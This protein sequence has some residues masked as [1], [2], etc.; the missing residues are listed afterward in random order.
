MLL[1]STQFPHTPSLSFQKHPPFLPPPSFHKKG[2]SPYQVPGILPGS[3]GP[4]D[5]VPFHMRL[6][7]TSGRHVGM[8]GLCHHTLQHTLIPQGKG[9]MG[10][11]HLKWSGKASPGER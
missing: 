9:A 8:P 4:A 1:F 2:L 5:L 7:D 3:G 6:P 11:A 10:R